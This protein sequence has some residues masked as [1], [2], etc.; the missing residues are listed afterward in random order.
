MNFGL[1]EASSGGREPGYLLLIAQWVFSTVGLLALGYCAWTLAAAY[2]F[3]TYQSWRLDQAREHRPASV[4]AFLKAE[5]AD[6][7]VQ[8]AGRSSNRALSKAP[9]GEIRWRPEA[10]SLLGRIEVPR[11]GLS[12]IVLEGDDTKVL[13]L[14]VGH[15]SVTALPGQV[16]NTAVA[17]HRD[18]FFRGLRNVRVN[19]EIRFT[20]LGGTYRYRVKSTEVVS[21]DD[22][23][24]LKPTLE[25]TLTLVT[26]YPFNF[27]GSAPERFIVRAEEVPLDGTQ[28]G[29]QS[30]SLVAMVSPPL[31]A[32]LS[33]GSP[34]V[35]RRSAVHPRQDTS[36]EK[37]LA[38]PE[39]PEPA[40]EASEVVSDSPTPEQKTPGLAARVRSRWGRL[41]AHLRGNRKEERRA[42]SP[43]AEP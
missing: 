27:V 38:P 40:S 33:E 32:G 43:E 16:G 17:G 36:Q 10:G 15:I 3:Q 20:T 22:T 14:A 31:P 2:L 23:S 11:L 12:S 41:F 9:G 21:P 39:P 29:G 18:T 30:A 28:A 1:R 4:G 13:R 34:A 8:I 42:D 7:W 5:V 19:D 25:R 37:A 24:A 26:C 35:P 6:L